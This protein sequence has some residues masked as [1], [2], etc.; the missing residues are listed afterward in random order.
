MRAQ[1]IVL[2]AESSTSKTVTIL[3]TRRRST[4]PDGGT[5]AEILAEIA[6]L[7]ALVSDI[8]AKLNRVLALLER[9]TSRRRTDTE[10]ARLLAALARSVAGMTFTAGH[11]F[12]HA[13]VAGG[14]LREAL[15]ACHVRTAQQ[16]GKRLEHL[17]GHSVDGLR[18]VRVSRD[19]TGAIWAVV[20]DSDDPIV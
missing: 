7:K 9:R 8:D 13:T 5:N 1:F 18:V 16:L 15:Q 10:R 19:A 6:D 4:P 2:L 14:A 12:D 20:A 3:A 11:L 17:Q